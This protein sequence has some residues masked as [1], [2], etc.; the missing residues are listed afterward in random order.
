MIDSNEKESVETV[1]TYAATTILI[2]LLSLQVF[3][4]YVLRTNISW[5]EEVSRIAFVWAIYGC[6]AYAAKH[7]K[8][9]R[10]SFLVMALPAKAQRWVLAFADVIWMAM[11]VLITYQSIR[12]IQHL[13]RFPFI[14]QTLGINRVYAYFVVPIGFLLVTYRIGQNLVRR[15]RT[16]EL[17][18]YDSRLDT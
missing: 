3:L 16:D 2:V 10:L 1:L 4:R 17:D 18:I 11:N 6:I 12:Y 5:S 7:D 14:S 15:F 13:F 9:I 8:H